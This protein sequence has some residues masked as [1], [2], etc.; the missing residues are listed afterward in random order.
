MPTDTANL[1][2]SSVTELY[3]NIFDWLKAHDVNAAVII[4][5]MLVVAFFNMTSALLILVLE[6]TRMIAC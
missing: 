4:G 6:R 5:I 2:V 1:A 3:P